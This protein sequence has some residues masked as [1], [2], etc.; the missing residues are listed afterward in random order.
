[1]DLLRDTQAPHDRTCVIVAHAR[2]KSKPA[3]SKMAR[4]GRHPGKDK[5]SAVDLDSG[6]KGL[7]FTPLEKLEVPPADA[8]QPQA[9]YT[10]SKQG[11]AA[12]E[13]D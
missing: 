9:D 8:C 5:H 4:L 2:G 12:M 11:Q 1:V 13:M 3:L 6:Q 7:I 10:R